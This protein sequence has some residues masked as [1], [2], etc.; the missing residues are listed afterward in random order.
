MRDRV[1]L[2]QAWLAEKLAAPEQWSVRDRDD[3]VFFIEKR[4]RELNKTPKDHQ[5]MRQAREDAL[6]RLEAAMEQHIESKADG[7]WADSP[8]AG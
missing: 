2:T 1:N 7:P 3:I 6:A 5:P 8:P 4:R